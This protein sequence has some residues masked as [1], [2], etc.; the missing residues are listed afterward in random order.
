M[1]ISTSITLPEIS[2]SSR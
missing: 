1:H 2:R